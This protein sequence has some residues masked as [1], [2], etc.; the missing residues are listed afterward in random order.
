MSQNKAFRLGIA[1]PMGAGKTSLVEQLSRSLLGKRTLAAVVNEIYAR[2]DAAYL[3]ANKVLPRERIK[4]VLTGQRPYDTVVAMNIAAVEE[5]QGATRRLDLI[6]IETICDVTGASFSPDVADAWIYMIDVANGDRIPRKGSP[7]LSRSDMLIVNK[8][9]LAAMVNV[10]LRTM[11]REC[12]LLRG[13]RPIVFTNL[14]CGHGLVHVVD[15]LE[16]II[17]Q[18]DESANVAGAKTMQYAL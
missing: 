5:L 16:G 2:E 14:R 1:G 8:I 15:W 3:M 17:G 13:E 11:E 6:L 10:S 4:S 18:S 12:R 7:G 9:D